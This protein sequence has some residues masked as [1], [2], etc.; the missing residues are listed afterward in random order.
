MS[1]IILC[2]IAILALLLI[3]FMIYLLLEK[4]FGKAILLILMLVISVVLGE[5]AENLHN[6]V[7]NNPFSIMQSGTSNANNIVENALGIVLSFV[8]FFFRFIFPSTSSLA[9]IIMKQWVPINFL[10]FM[11]IL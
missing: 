11:V 5:L 2:I 3:A 4:S 8:L 6:W 7:D 9:N 1:S 10:R